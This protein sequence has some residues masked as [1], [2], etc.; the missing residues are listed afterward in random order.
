ME[1]RMTVCN[2]AIEAGA[3]SGMV[4]VDEKTIE[5]VRGPAVLARRCDV[6]AGRGRVAP[7]CAPT[8]VRTSTT[9]SNCARR[10]SSRR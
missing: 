1:G 4:A 6:R 3:R 5:Y 7:V 2:M 9:S 8:R 10:R